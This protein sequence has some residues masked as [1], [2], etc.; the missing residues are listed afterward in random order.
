[1]TEAE[2]VYTMRGTKRAERKLRSFGVYKV[3]SLQK[4]LFFYFI[5]T[6]VKNII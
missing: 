6:N 1:M 5:L 3:I 2:I 4:V